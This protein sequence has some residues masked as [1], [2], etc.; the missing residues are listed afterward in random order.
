MKKPQLILAYSFFGLLVVCFFMAFISDLAS[1][2]SL[3]DAFDY[4]SYCWGIIISWFIDIILAVALIALSCKALINLY[5]DKE[6]DETKAFKSNCLILSLYLFVAAVSGILVLINASQLGIDISQNIVLLVF[7]VLAVVCLFM[8]TRKYEKNVV[9]KV[10][11]GIGYLILFVFLIISASNGVSGFAVAYIIFM[12]LAV[13]VGAVQI[14]IYD[15]DLLQFVKSFKNNQKG[16]SSEPEKNENDD[17][18][19][20]LNKLQELHSQGLISDEEYEQKRKEII[21][22]L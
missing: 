2:K 3:I 10:I 1:I 19:N 21:E 14:G 11:A 5:K 16:P 15:V 17:S 13:I 7:Q 6:F 12:F 4:F 8:A 20:R 18:L 9:N 22:K